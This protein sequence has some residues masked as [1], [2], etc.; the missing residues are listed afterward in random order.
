M[1]FIQNLQNKSDSRKKMILFAS[2]TIFMVLVVLVWIFQMKNNSA[3]RLQTQTESESQLSPISDLKDNIVNLYNESAE[4]IGDI[5][6]GFEYIS[7]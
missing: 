4:K 3:R 6:E 5:R 2:V 1:N 7:R